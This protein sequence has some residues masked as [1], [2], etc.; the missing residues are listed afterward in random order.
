MSPEEREK[1]DKALRAAESQLTDALSPM[2]GVHALFGELM[3]VGFTEN[4]IRGARW[5]GSV[6][7][8]RPHPAMRRIELNSLPFEIQPSSTAAYGRHA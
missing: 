6:I 3:K 2:H 7:S 4:L 1:F 5:A 8:Y